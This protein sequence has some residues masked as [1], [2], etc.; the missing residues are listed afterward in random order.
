MKRHSAIFREL[1]LIGL[2]ILIVTALAG[3][4]RPATATSWRPIETSQ[5]LETRQALATQEDA[6][7]TLPAPTPTLA[8]P[9]PT[10]ESLPDSL[11]K[12]VKGYELYSW[13]SGHDW[14]FTLI[15]GTN[16]AKAFDEIIAPGNSIGG[17]GFVKFSV[18]GIAEIEKLVALLPANEQVFWSGMDLGDQ[19][20]SGTVYL[21][22]PPQ[23]VIEELVKF[24][25][26]H[27]V[28]LQLLKEP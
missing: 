16:R 26:D 25:A 2:A 19:V 4:E 20:P 28:Q 27:Q 21:T 18:T 8:L 1:L 7:R 6:Y 9:F 15:T 11:P 10:P 5:N 14:N 22:F 23:N 13:Q 17:D 24:C 3:C 12:S